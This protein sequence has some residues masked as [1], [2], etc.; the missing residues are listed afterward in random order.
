[1]SDRATVDKAMAERIITVP[2]LS[3][4]IEVAQHGDPAAR[5]LF[6]DRAISLGGA[7]A[8]LLDV[9]N[10]EVLMVTEAG[11]IHLPDCLDLLHE[12]V[13]RRSHV[14]A[15]PTRQVRTPSFAPDDLL[16]VAAGTVLLDVVYTNPASTENLAGRHFPV[17]GLT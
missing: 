4:L 16:A 17:R 12:Q 2:S 7:V 13:R 11:L 14:G 6:H 9:L 10:P 1:V 3:T 15:D 8:L 5:R